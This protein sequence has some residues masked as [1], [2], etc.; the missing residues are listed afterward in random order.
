MSLFVTSFIFIENLNLQKWKQNQVTYY[1][2]RKVSLQKLVLFSIKTFHSK[3]YCEKNKYSRWLFIKHIT[4]SMK[5]MNISELFHSKT[6][7]VHKKL[8]NRIKVYFHVKRKVDYFFV[9]VKKNPILKQFHAIFFPYNTSIALV[10]SRLYTSKRRN[11]YESVFALQ[12][13][14]RYAKMQITAT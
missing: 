14:I 4:F 13:R 3:L 1:T 6:R 7:F 8:W 10:A 11:E 5:I 9:S 2:D 12:L